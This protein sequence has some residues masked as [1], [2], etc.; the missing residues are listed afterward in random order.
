MGIWQRQKEREREKARDEWEEMKLEEKR[1][2]AL[3]MLEEMKK[4]RGEDNGR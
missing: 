1:L 3:D 2:D 4:A